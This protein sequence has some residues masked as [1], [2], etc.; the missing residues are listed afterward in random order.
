MQLGNEPQYVDFGKSAAL[1]HDHRPPLGAEYYAHLAQHGIGLEG[2]TIADLGCGTGLV[3]Q[4][5][6]ERGCNVVGVDV[7]RELLEVARTRASDS[8]LNIQYVQASAEDTG[9]PPQSFDAVTAATCWHYFNHDRALAEVRRLLVPGGR[10][11]VSWFYWLPLPGS[12]AE[13]T[14][15]LVLKH[16]PAWLYGGVLGISGDAVKRFTLD[17]GSVESYSFD[18]PVEFTHT[19]WRLRLRSCGG[20]GPALSHDAVEVFDAELAGLL[21]AYPEPLLVLHRNF[22]IVGRV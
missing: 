22:V 15:A 7:S 13:A 18:H 14:E 3:S 17:L 8:G 2:Q 11:A 19:A 20:I 9:L 4:V 12:V 5:L 1:F 10:L 6:A 16:N 21:S